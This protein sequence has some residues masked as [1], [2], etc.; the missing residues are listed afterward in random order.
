M[1][2]TDV[3]R[4]LIEPRIA[5]LVAGRAGIPD[6]EEIPDACRKVMDEVV[7]QGVSSSEGGKRLRALLALTAYDAFGGE[8][9]TRDAMVDM[10]CAIEVFQT[11]A[12]VHDDIIDESDLRRG[13]PSAHKAL[14][15]W[16]G[17]RAIGRGLGLMLGDLLATACVAIANEAA[18]SLPNSA[19]LVDAFLT[20][21]REVEI[22]QVLDLAVEQAP[23][24]D[25]DA[26]V[27]ASLGVFRWKTASYTTIAP[28]RLAMLASGCDPQHAER[29][30]TA[31]GR[32]LGLAFQLED[33]LIDVI[34]SSRSSGKPVGG[35]IREGK[36]TVLLADAIGAADADG[37]AELISM[38]EAE[39]RSQ[40][41]V[42]R[43]MELFGATGAIDRSKSRIAALWDQTSHAID[44][45]GLDADRRADLTAMCAMFVPDVA[46]R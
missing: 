12:L 36:R 18:H 1:C 29:T 2:R 11:A 33:D 38:F 22:G 31:I 24:D 42:R 19:K 3:D 45:S 16:T 40:D 4:S 37:R 10:A 9:R 7:R 8:P 17:D 15:D 26:L 5:A 46:G 27:E 25:P 20:M 41:D 23:L 6:G 39:S 28:L 43:T 35:D 34:G 13:R 21:Q 32:P 30:A 44:A 14:E